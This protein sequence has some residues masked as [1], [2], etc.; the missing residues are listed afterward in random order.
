MNNPFKKLINKSNTLGIFWG[1]PVVGN[2]RHD[3]ENK[4]YF[5]GWDRGGRSPLGPLEHRGGQFSLF[6]KIQCFNDAIFPNS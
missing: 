5:W 3:E 6:L 1:F 4:M 2:I